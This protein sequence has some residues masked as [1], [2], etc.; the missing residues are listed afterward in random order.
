MVQEINELKKV[1]VPWVTI[2]TVAFVFL[3]A[4]NI[5]KEQVLGYSVFL[6][7]PELNSLSLSLFQKI[8][9]DLLPSGIKVLVT[10]PLN[11][12]M[13]QLNVSLFFAFLISLP[14]LLYRVV[15]Y[16]SP[17]LYKRE[18]KTLVALIMPSVLLFVG[19]CIFGYIFIIPSTIRLL[20]VYLVSLNA[21]SYFE[22]NKF[23]SFVLGFTFVCGL[24]FVLPI[25]MRTLS[26]IGAVDRVFW[27]KNFKYFLLG[28]V[29]FSIIIAPDITSMVVLSF[30]L[31]S[32]YTLG[33]ILS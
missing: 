3:L 33:F 2:F 10:S 12:L 5:K 21:A 28:I 31:I 17:A 18:K 8:Q 22:I 29:V 30:I 6:P 20:S 9:H 23:I 19:G 14:I 27:V 16:L 32:L 25:F 13:V 1:F 4:F 24:S 11:A 7:I 26:S 15:S